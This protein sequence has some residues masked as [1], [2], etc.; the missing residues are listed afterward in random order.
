MSSAPVRIDAW[1]DSRMTGPSANELKKSASKHTS[2]VPYRS[3]DMPPFS[4]HI[5][6]KLILLPQTP[7][8]KKAVH[9]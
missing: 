8:E 6:Q 5:S 9:A 3:N 2:N 7:Y 4:T 1:S